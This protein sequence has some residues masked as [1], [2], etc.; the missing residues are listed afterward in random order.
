MILSGQEILSLAGE[1]Y[2]VVAAI[3]VGITYLIAML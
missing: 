2:M 1:S 3:L